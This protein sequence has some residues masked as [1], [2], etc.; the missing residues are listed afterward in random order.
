MPATRMTILTRVI[1]L[2]AR[3]RRSNGPK[4]TVQGKDVSCRQFLPYLVPPTTQ[5]LDPSPLEM[6]VYLPS[7]TTSLDSF[8]MSL[9]P[10][11]LMHPRPALSQPFRLCSVP[12]SELRHRIF[13]CM[14]SRPTVARWGCTAHRGVDRRAVCPVSGLWAEVQGWR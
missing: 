12:A 4:F 1:V 7:P 14:L 2:D 5:N 9:G 10:G 11:L 13:H 3:R 8:R 6:M